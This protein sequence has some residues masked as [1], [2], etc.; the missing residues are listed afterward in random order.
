MT[1]QAPPTLRYPRPTANVTMASGHRTTSID[2][3]SPATT[4]P[5]TTTP[6]AVA[7]THTANQSA[8]TAPAPGPSGIVSAT[9][10]A[11]GT[12]GL[13]TP[14]QQH[15][16]RGAVAQHPF[17]HRQPQPRD[18]DRSGREKHIDGVDD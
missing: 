3:E 7:Q 4:R 15:G 12:D 11:S 14:R 5:A 17:G 8:A 1:S 18:H 6:P 16:R 2:A 13:R 10:A 9:T